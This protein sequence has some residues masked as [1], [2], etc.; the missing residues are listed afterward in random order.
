MNRGGVGAS[1]SAGF[2]GGNLYLVGRMI[3]STSVAFL[4]FFFPWVCGS[5]DSFLAFAVGFFV[6]SS[7]T[8]AREFR[9]GLSGDAIEGACLSSAG[10]GRF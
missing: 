10:R 9:S 8:R 7:R 6:R 2:G 5:G 4:L 1:K 3:S